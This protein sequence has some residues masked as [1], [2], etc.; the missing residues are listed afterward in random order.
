MDFILGTLKRRNEPL[1]H[2]TIFQKKLKFVFLFYLYR[3][4]VK[5]GVSY[6]LFQC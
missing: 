1:M 5:K 2:V 6:S 3:K 4:I